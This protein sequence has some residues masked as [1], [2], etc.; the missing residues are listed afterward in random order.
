MGKISWRRTSFRFPG[1]NYTG[2]DT[3]LDL[4][5]DENDKPKSDELNNTSLPTYE[6]TDQDNE[7]IIGSLPLDTKKPNT[8][9]WINKA[10][11]YFVDQ[12]GDTLKDDIDMNNLKLIE[13]PLEIDNDAVHKKY[14]L[15]QINSIEV[16]KNHLEDKISD[17]KRYFKHQQVTSLKSCIQQQLVNVV[18][19]IQLQNLSSSISQ[20]DDNI[21]KQKI[22]NIAA[23]GKNE[24]TFQQELTA[25]ETKFNTELQKE[26]T[27]IIQLIQ[28]IDDSEIKTYIQQQIQNIDDSEIKT[29]IQQQI[30]NI[31]DSEIKTYIQ[32]Q[33]QN[34]DDSEIKTYIQQQIQN[35]DESK[36]KT[37]IQ[38]Q[39]QNIDEGVI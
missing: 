38:Q 18:N 32:Q 14:L 22:D 33:I 15:D 3:R 11:H 9:A 8:T 34:I 23:P 37:Y 13:S 39:I 30:Q 5:L 17:A 12:I 36:I 7:Q 31:D 27:N 2:P 1:H 28:N 24:D 35:I 29:Y 10:K 19:K 4:R 16:D 20:L 6:L 25:L 26:L 21:T